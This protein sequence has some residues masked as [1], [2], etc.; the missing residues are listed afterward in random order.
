[1]GQPK[2]YLCM[3]EAKDK[4][5]NFP[6]A[7]RLDQTSVL[8]LETL[9]VHLRPEVSLRPLSKCSRTKRTR[10]QVVLPWSQ[11]QV[12]TSMDGIATREGVISG[13]KLVEARDKAGANAL[14]YAA[15]AGNRGETENIWK[16]AYDYGMFSLT[17]SL[18]K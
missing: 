8:V 2:S 6:L 5:T 1:M 16:V 14:H 18:Q 17:D 15:M 4:K 10:T 7:E 3:G 12:K 13:L 9:Y 11:R